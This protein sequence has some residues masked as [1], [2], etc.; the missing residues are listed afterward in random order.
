MSALGFVYIHTH[1]HTHIYIYMYVCPRLAYDIP[2]CSLTLHAL[3]ATKVTNII[4]KIEGTRCHVTSRQRRRVLARCLNR[5][6]KKHD[7]HVSGYSATYN[8]RNVSVT[9]SCFI[10]CPKDRLTELL[11]WDGILRRGCGRR[12]PSAFPLASGDSHELP[13][14]LGFRTSRRYLNTQRLTW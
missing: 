1:T 11:S 5:P 2:L 4:P 10:R 14:I 12:A 7:I 8:M 9:L 13:R 3:Y 6:K